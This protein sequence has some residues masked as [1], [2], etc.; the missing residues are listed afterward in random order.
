MLIPE[1]AGTI[2]AVW[3]RSLWQCGF[4]RPFLERFRSPS[5]FPFGTLSV[6]LAL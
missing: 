3:R 2:E 6:A 4:L 5:I 1:D